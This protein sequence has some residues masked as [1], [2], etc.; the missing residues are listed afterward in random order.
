MDGE[1]VDVERV[2]ALRRLLLDGN[3]VVLRVLGSCAEG[4]GKAEG[5]GG[6]VE[7]D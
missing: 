1:R 4:G 5:G 3:E 2:D 7:G 6:C